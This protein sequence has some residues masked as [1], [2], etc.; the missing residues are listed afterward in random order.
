LR[1]RLGDDLVTRLRRCIGR[2]LPARSA[3]GGTKIWGKIGRRSTGRRCQCARRRRSSA[4]P[5]AGG[6]RGR[7]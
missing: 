2:L 3:R 6:G 4:A 5:A 1:R 7:D